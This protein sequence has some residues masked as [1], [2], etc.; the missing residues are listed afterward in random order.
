MIQLK[1]KAMLIVLVYINGDKMIE[2]VPKS[3]TVNP[4]YIMKLRERAR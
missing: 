3:Q 4:K 1:L 2:L